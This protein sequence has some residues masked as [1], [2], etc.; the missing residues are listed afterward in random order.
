[1]IEVYVGP[2]GE[3]FKINEHLLC[4]MS[5]YFLHHF[6]NK[7]PVPV[8]EPELL[9]ANSEFFAIFHHYCYSNQ[10]VLPKAP[11]KARGPTLYLLGAYYLAEK[12]AAQRFKNAIVDQLSRELVKKD[13]PSE[14]FAKWAKQLFGKAH[15]TP[16]RLLFTNAF[17]LIHKDH[18]REFESGAS[19]VDM[20][21]EL[22]KMALGSAKDRPKQKDLKI[23]APE[24]C[25]NYHE[26]DHYNPSWICQAERQVKNP[27]LNKKPAKSARG[28]GLLNS[29]S[30]KARKEIQDDEKYEAGLRKPTKKRKTEGGAVATA[31]VEDHDDDGE[32]GDNI[33]FQ[34]GTM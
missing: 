1:M 27:F 24:Y 26:H 12:L 8:R 19:H 11:T 29:Y 28:N 30:V 18:Y 4:H 23:D 20:K 2:K 16:L 3:K 31:F 15:A 14:K 25:R 6:R 7:R 9:K 32:E 22:L 33:P 21:H 34:L 17:Y 13:T 5:G 10:I